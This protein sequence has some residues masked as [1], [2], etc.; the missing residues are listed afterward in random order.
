MIDEHKPPRKFTDH[1]IF[2]IGI[3]LGLGTLFNDD[4]TGIVCWLHQ[5]RNDLG[6][7]SPMD[8]IATGDMDKIKAVVD[9]LDE[10]RNLR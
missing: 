1:Q 2:M 7:E 10:V 6:D 4:T 8:Y 3:G 9:V 5:K